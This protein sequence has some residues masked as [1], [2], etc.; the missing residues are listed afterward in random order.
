M[1]RSFILFLGAA[2]TGCAAAFAPTNNRLSSSARADATSLSMARALIVQN[3]GGGHGELGFQIAEK[4]S[5]DEKID[6]ITI[7]QDNSCDLEAEPFKFYSSHLPD[8]D[9]IYAKLGDE[10]MD[11]KSIQ[12]LLGGEEFEYIW[13]NYSKGPEGSSKALCDIAKDWGCLKLY[14]YIS[15]AGMYQPTD[16][17]EFP[18]SEATTPI[19]A[20]S[21]QAKMDNYIAEEC[22]LP[23]VSFRP[24]YIYGEKSNKHD[25]IDWYFDRLSLDAPLLIP[26][27]GTQKVSLTNSKDVA[28]LLVA[29]LDNEEAAIEQRYFNCGT[30]KLLTY[31][32]VAF[33]CAEAAGIAKEDV[34]IQHYSGE[35]F[36]KAKFPFRLTDFYIAPD[37]AKEKLGYGG[38]MN[39]LKGDLKWYYENYK[40]RD[41]KNVDLTKDQEI[42][43]KL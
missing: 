36:G 23:L 19:K 39:D 4:L 42:L 21:G 8:V 12:D 22:K 6:K 27:P 25:Y 1:V 28:S 2:F 41:G 34:K 43:A 37:L 20:S 3:K 7:L 18:M 33:L 15:S 24:Q 14:V 11:A 32:E 5:A 16:A 26:S 13:D 31:D 29:P 40:G 38:A 10:S 9:V 30:D 35:T 17:T